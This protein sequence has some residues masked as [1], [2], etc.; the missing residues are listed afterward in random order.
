MRPLSDTWPRRWLLFLLAAALV[1]WLTRTY[2]PSFLL[3]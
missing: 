1:V 3:H 2:Y